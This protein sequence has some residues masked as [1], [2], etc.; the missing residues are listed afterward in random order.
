MFGGGMADENDRSQ[1]EGRRVAAGA[2]RSVV[3]LPRRDAHGG[4]QAG[5]PDVVPQV[6]ESLDILTEACGANLFGVVFF[7]SVLVGTSPTQDSAADLFVVVED[8]K[9]FYRDLGSRLPAARSAGVMSVLNK[10]LAPNVIYLRNPGDLRA[11]AKCFVIDRE[12]FEKSLS[13]GARDHFC[14]GRLIQRVQVVQARSEEA[15]EA[16]ENALESA[17][18]VALE[19]VPLYLPRTFGPLDFCRRMLEVSYRGEIRPESRSR[20][21]E[22]FEAQKT[23]FLLMFGRLLEGAVAAGQLERAGNEYRLPHKPGVSARAWWR[24][25]FFRSK[26]RATLRWFKYM[27]TF[28]DWLD[29]IARKAERRTGVHLE[30]SKAER[31]FPVLLLWP[32]LF[33]VL[34]AMRSR[35]CGE[36]S[37]AA[38]PLGEG[39]VPD[40]K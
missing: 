30:L 6:R 8:Y 21:Q 17:R 18:R 22:V 15:R 13:R 33:R 40:E 31:R 4:Q 25:F 39:R 20:V 10:V 27:L 11:G 28:E 9:R 2:R 24:F 34:K 7:G 23:Y 38:R 5:A 26:V 1:R 16:I 36:E 32:K 35:D 12:G 19:W 14:R 29:Y 37:N 3:P